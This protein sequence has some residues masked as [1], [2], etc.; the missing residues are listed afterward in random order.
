MEPRKIKFEELCEFVK[1]NSKYEERQKKDTRVKDLT[2]NLYYFYDTTKMIVL[3]EGEKRTFRG[4]LKPQVNWVGIT[5]SGKIVN[6][7]AELLRKF[8]EAYSF[9]LWAGAREKVIKWLESEQKSKS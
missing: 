2:G 8:N 6:F 9:E 3:Y 4:H 1:A 7:Q 5:E